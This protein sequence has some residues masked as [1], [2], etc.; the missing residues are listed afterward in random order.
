MD[1]YH[2]LL[3]ICIVQ[4]EQR[5]HLT[6]ASDLVYIAIAGSRVYCFEYNN[7]AASRPHAASGLFAAVTARAVSSLYN[8]L[9]WSSVCVCVCMTENRERERFANMCAVNN[10]VIG[11]RIFPHKRYRLAAISTKEVI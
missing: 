9:V 2:G 1:F 3:V 6:T 5:I 8:L 10:I 7:M 11:G 4:P